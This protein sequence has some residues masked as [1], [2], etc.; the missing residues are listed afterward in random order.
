MSDLIVLYR[1]TCLAEDLRCSSGEAVAAILSGELA[2]PDG[3]AM[4]AAWMAH[5][6]RRLAAR[7][8]PIPGAYDPRRIAASELEVAA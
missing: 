3:A 4:A 7:R 5:R 1:L 2:L 6:R 8:R